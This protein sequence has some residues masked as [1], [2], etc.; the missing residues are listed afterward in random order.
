MSAWPLRDHLDLAAL[1]TAAACARLH[2]KLVLWEWDMAWLADSAELITSELVTNAIKATRA[3]GGKGLPLRLRL[4]ADWARLLL[5]VW[6]AS[7]ALPVR[8]RALPDDEHGRGLGVVEALGASWGSYHPP[9]R[10]GKVVW[11]LIDPEPATA[12][13][14]QQ[15][16]RRR[17]PAPDSQVPGRVRGRQQIRHRA[18]MAAR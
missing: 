1:P 14:G 6:D 13:P 10:R 3:L 15:P 7:P 17:H 5:E 12:R 2:T 8:L 11:S 4:S 9:D 18:A 16:G